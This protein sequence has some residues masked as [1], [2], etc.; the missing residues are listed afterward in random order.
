MNK[1]NGALYASIL[2]GVIITVIL[3]SFVIYPA[4][5]SNQNGSAPA[6]NRS[7]FNSGT[8]GVGN[9]SVQFTGLD[10]DSISH[11]NNS[12]FVD[13]YPSPPG[14]TASGVTND[15]AVFD[16]LSGNYTVHE[17][18]SFKKSQMTVITN[19]TSL[20]VTQTF[21][22]NNTAGTKESYSLN[23]FAVVG[24]LQNATLYMNSPSG[25]IG[26]TVDISPQTYGLTESYSFLGSGPYAIQF[27]ADG[28][29]LNWSSLD[30]LLYSGELSFSHDTTKLSLNYSQVSLLPGSSLVL[31]SI[32]LY[33]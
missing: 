3:I 28:T 6:F 12:I 8:V 7:D 32:Q 17:N 16:N 33:E 5:I 31:G 30:G 29:Y 25:P 10:F 24:G 1:R 4:L 18:I 15:H 20:G 27:Q 23:Y 11:N 19:I 21:V 2:A 13:A 22:L 26:K 9:M 14:E